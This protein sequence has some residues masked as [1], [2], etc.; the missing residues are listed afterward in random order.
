MPYESKTSSLINLLH[1]SEQNLNPKIQ[2][3]SKTG[4]LLFQNETYHSHSHRRHKWL[5]EEHT[6]TLP[7]NCHI[8]AATIPLLRAQTFTQ[9]RRVER[10]AVCRTD[11]VESCGGGGVD[12]GDETAGCR[13]GDGGG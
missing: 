9:G 6:R 3:T 12:T 8:H 11:Q 10:V 2:D 13:D 5:K 7:R 1:R 4:Q